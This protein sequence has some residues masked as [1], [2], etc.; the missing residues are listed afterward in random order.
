HPSLTITS[1]S[2]TL[3]FTLPK[4]VDQPKNVLVVVSNP[5]SFGVTATGSAPLSFQWSKDGTNLVGQTATNLVIASVQV[6][7][8]GSYKVL[9]SNN[10]GSVTSAPASLTLIPPPFAVSA[11]GT[12]VSLGGPAVPTGLDDV[13]AIA[14][15]YGQQLAVRS[16][17]TVVCWGANNTPGNPPQPPPDLSNVVA[18]ASG[19][20]HSIALKRYA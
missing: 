15:G 14:A 11:P 20:L 17:G 1:S 6:T 10:F 13:V 2:A 7:D 4:I 8:A 19:G 3:S 12:V 9:V 16:N 18:V 5:A